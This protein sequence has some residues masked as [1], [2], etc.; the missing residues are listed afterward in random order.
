MN[1]SN[2]YDEYFRKKR[3]FNSRGVGEKSDMGESQSSGLGSFEGINKNLQNQ[4]EASAVT[5]ESGPIGGGVGYENLTQNDGMDIPSAKPSPNYSGSGMAAANTMSQGGDPMDVASSA[6][7][8]SGN[9]YAMGAALGLQTISSI[10]KAKQQREQNKYVAEV[11]RVKARQDAIDRL[12]S[13]GQN[14]RA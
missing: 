12:A 14:L 8:A 3:N 11:Q 2:R 6:A 9:P 13:I 1:S 7:M 5:D 4:I 10:N